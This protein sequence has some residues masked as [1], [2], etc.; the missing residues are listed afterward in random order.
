M[1]LRGSEYVLGEPETQ[2]LQNESLKKGT[3]RSFFPKPIFV[4]NIIF[5]AFLYISVFNIQLTLK[6]YSV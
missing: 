5:A 4:R 6:L 2:V 1:I 3:F